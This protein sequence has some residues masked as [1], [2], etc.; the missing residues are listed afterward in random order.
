MFFL[1]YM[2]HNTSV[3]SYPVV[4]FSQILIRK[5][6]SVFHLCNT[7]YICNLILQL[8]VF[9]SASILVSTLI[10]FNTSLYIENLNNTQSR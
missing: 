7:P 8:Y 2:L 6:D 5:E 3:F 4:V 1:L 9:I 10:Q